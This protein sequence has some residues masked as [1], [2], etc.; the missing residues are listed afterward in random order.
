[1]IAGAD[2]TTFLIL[3]ILGFFLLRN[4][5]NRSMDAIDK[6][7]ALFAFRQ[8][9]PFDAVVVRAPLETLL[10]GIMLLV[11]L[12]GAALFGHP[13]VP[14]DPLGALLALGALG[15]GG[16]GLGLVFSVLGNLVEE[17]K[18]VVRLMLT[19][20]YLLSAVIYPSIAVPR[21]MRDAFLL[22]PIV[23]GVESLRIAF[24]PAY[25]VPPGIDLAYLAG[26]GLAMVFLG[27]ALHVRYQSEL[28]AK[29][30]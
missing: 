13:I 15:L 7:E 6:S 5:M 26:F 25:H 20:L 28:K 10:T 23:H 17:A 3:G 8:V 19:P 24:M 27:L 21:S 14:A 2:L 9:K 30:G 11:M 29:A 22:N 18:R 12:V 4:I 16:L 1:V